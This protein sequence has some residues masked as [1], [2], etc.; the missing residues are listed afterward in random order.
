M[1][2][3]PIETAPKDDTSVDLWVPY[4]ENDPTLGR[5]VTDMRREDWGDGNVF[6]M[7]E[8][9]GPSCLRNASHWMP[10]PGAPEA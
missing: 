10:V 9:S 2:W 7:A 3:Q 6:Y 4:L 5:R 1:T 8:E